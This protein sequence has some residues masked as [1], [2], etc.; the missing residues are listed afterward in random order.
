MVVVEKGMP[1]STTQELMAV[2]QYV[3]TQHLGVSRGE[4]WLQNQWRNCL[5]QLAQ[6]R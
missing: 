6:L 4:R 3:L 5:N 1:G 2:G